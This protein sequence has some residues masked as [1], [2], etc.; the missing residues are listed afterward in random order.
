VE[1]RAL[2]VHDLLFAEQAAHAT[3]KEKLRA[4]NRALDDTRLELKKVS[5]RLGE[6]REASKSG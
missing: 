3:T 2:T 5:R 4:A 6:K 1:V